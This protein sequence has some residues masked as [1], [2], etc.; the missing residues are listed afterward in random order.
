[1][2]SGPHGR[3]DARSARPDWAA[4]IEAVTFDCYG[5]LVDWEE[6]ISRAVGEVLSSRGLSIGR[7]PL[8]QMYGSL[9]SGI[10]AGE[11]V[12]YREVLR[13][14]MDGI[15]AACG[16]V[17]TDTERRALEESLPEWPVFTDTPEALRSLGRGRRLVILSNVDDDLIQRSIE[18]IGVS[19]DGVVTAQQVRSY[20]PAEAHFAEGL[21]RLGI[22]PTRVLHAAQSL[23]HDVGVATRLGFR[24]AW[25]N[26]QQGRVGA[27]PRAEA[28]PD[29]EVAD[30]AELARLMDV[31]T[32]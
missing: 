21:R 11:Y 13:R 31:G 26:R 15:G 2:E 3:T 29:V 1:M 12:S 20:K 19:F 4:D 27:T 18:C 30:L 17:P 28:V 32:T 16:F 9:E 5:T 23:Y 8:L 10:E 7:D 24:T 22:A 6:G 14:A 25:I